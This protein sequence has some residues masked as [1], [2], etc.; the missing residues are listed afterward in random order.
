MTETV[1]SLENDVVSPVR[2]KVLV[3]KVGENVTLWAALSSLYL[4]SRLLTQVFT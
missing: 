2:L 1:P 3:V 4:L